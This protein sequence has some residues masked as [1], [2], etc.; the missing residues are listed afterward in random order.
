VR[1]TAYRDGETLAFVHEIGLAGEDGA[2][3]AV[4]VEQL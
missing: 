2:P 1:T 4:V 3:C